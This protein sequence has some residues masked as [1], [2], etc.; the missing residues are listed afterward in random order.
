MKIKCVP[1]LRVWKLSEKNAQKLFLEK[2][3]S[4]AGERC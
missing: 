1:R 2:V 4:L 3:A